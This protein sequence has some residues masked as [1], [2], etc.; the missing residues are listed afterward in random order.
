M[1][2]NFGVLTPQSQQPQI[3]N[4]KPPT[5][6]P[7]SGGGDGGD[8]GIGEIFSGLSGLLGGLG[9]G[10]GGGGG[11][12]AG[13]GAEM[14]SSAAQSA[15]ASMPAQMPQPQMVQQP[16]SGI[17]GLNTGMQNTMIG[18]QRQYNPQQVNSN[19]AQ[20]G[21]SPQASNGPTQ[22]SSGQA[23]QPMAP[24]SQVPQEMM[25]RPAF[26]SAMQA[27]GVAKQQGLTKNSTMAVV[28]FSMPAN[29]PRMFV[30]DAD[31]GT[32]L[33]NTYVAQ[34]ATPGFS[35][36]PESHQSSL[37]TFQTSD[38]YQGK[39]GESMRINGLDKGVND[40]AFKRNIVVHGANYV[41]P[42]KSGTSWGCFAVPQGEVSSLI[43]LTQGGSLIHAYAP[44]KGTLGNLSQNM[45]AKSAANLDGIIN[46]T[47]SAKSAFNNQ[48]KQGSNPYVQQAIDGAKAAFPDNPTMA[49]MAAAQAIHESGLSSGKPSGLAQQNNYF[50]IKGQGTAGSVSMGTREFGKNG[51]YKT[52]ADFAKNS[53][54]VDS[55]NQY[56]T[57][58]GKDRYASYRNSKTPEEAAQ[59]LQKSGYATDPRYGQQVLDTYNKYVAP[60]MSN[61]S[62][63][64]SIHPPGP[65]TM[66]G[67]SRDVIVNGPPGRAGVGRQ[68]V[69][70]E[71]N[72]NGQVNPGA[73]S[74]NYPGR[75]IS[76]QASN[77]V[78]FGALTQPQQGGSKILMGGGSGAG[79]GQPGSPQGG[80]LMQAGQGSQQGPQMMGGTA[81]AGGGNQPSPMMSPVNGGLMN[82]FSSIY[83]QPP[84]QITNQG[85]LNWQGLFSNLLV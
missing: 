64:Q 41:G 81:M 22:M 43:G 77:G 6:P 59:A 71:T 83:N 34:G 25:Q 49:G 36:T 7:P 3:M 27:Y 17:S 4:I 12:D 13:A 21:F 30:M 61:P 44:D 47:S 19:M 54:P 60:N 48:G 24:G 29:Q 57:L 70:G 76:Q 23:V 20:G 18:G 65:Q 67:S 10:G 16:L 40:N 69:P 73:L 8:G 66:N 5:P 45:P 32:I 68:W 2:V 75:P 85:G 26:Q 74:P 33:K 38:V 53:S 78:N 46:P 1:P 15:I 14:A 39:H 9:G 63:L 52:T 82:A 62:P 72:D 55:F 84:P 42:D 50:G 11:G 58:I 31:K 28:D 35:N 56:K 80:A 37:G 79:M 51:S